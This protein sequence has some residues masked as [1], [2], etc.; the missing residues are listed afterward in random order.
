MRSLIIGI[1]RTGSPNDFV[2]NPD[3]KYI[4]MCGN[5]PEV[6]FS[7]NCGQHDFIKQINGLR[8][9]D[10][11]P[12]SSAGAIS[13]FQD[14]VTKLFEDIKYLQIEKNDITPLHIRLVTTPFELAQ[15]PFEFVLA[16]KDVTEG[17][18]IPLLA[19][20]GRKIT[21]TREVRQESEARYIWPSKPKILFAWA[22]P[23]GKEM[24]VPHDEHYAVLK[25]IVSP[26][27]KPKK[28]VPNPEPFVE[29]LLTELPNA[30]LQSIK[31]KLD[32]AIAEKS[33][34]THLHILAHGGEKNVLGVTEFQLIL[35]EDGTTD[36]PKKIDGKKLAEAFVP[37]DA[38]SV[39]T[40]ISLSVCDSG[41]VGN[42]I[43]PAGSLV[44]Q[45][46]TGG[47][48]CVF[49]SQFPLTQKGSVTLIKTLYQNLIDACDPRMAL[50]EA[51]MNLKK[52]SSHDWAS[53]VAYARFP[54][55]INEQLQDADLKNAFSTMKV[56]N[57]WVD[58]VFKFWGKI[59]DAKKEPA[60]K[61]LEQRLTRSIESLS[62]YLN[63]ENNME[64]K[65]ANA[66]LRAEHL[67]ILGSAYKRK[68]EYYF[69]LSDFFPARKEELLKQSREALNKAKDFY[70]YGFESNPASHWNSIQYLSLKAVTEG[71]LKDDQ[72][73]WFIT[74]LMAE[75]DEKKPKTEDDRIWA[76]GTLAELYLLQPLT[77][78]DAVTGE[79]SPPAN[80]AKNYMGKLAA[81]DKKYNEA[82]ISTA[83]QF[84]RYNNWW[85]SVFPETYPAKLK[86]AALEIRNLLPPLSELL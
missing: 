32:D 65:L 13:F 63:P 56:T 16:P 38:A 31:K 79:G 34:Y 3:N 49:A 51:R 39:P 72:E 80:E 2:L 30:S 54:E 45:L 6:S 69:R 57:A 15:L 12:S 71:T 52:E 22:Q 83:R 25:E 48:P 81:A 40:V 77:G 62:A 9:D 18:K 50:Y 73:R 53:L 44:Y 64:S 5:K 11:D 4:S 27:A 55:D 26:I 59:D 76:W 29:E 66:S 61:E 46:H 84:D 58:H 82:K 68:A 33:P 42:T 74:K 19:Y 21:L 17:E 75:R 41:N 60:L 70:N 20:P 43:M 7:I 1:A 10:A 24:S 23:G 14:L 36:K 28:E 86:E 35:C 67:G 78:N 85:P 47:V 8:Y 37:A